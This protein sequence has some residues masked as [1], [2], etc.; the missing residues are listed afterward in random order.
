MPALPEKDQQILASH[1][2]LVHAVVQTCHNRDLMP[3]LEQLLK[4]SEENGWNQLVASI[5]RIV[6]GQRDINLLQNLD[7][8]DRVITEAILRGLQNPETL[9]DLS[10]TPDPEHAAPGLASM[11]AAARHGN[12]EALKALADMAIQMRNAGGDM[13]RLASALSQ[14]EQGE[15]DVEK[16]SREMSPA[17]LKLVETILEELKKT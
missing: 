14:M 17:G 10:A 16:L 9:P 13:A 3:Q 2:G 1:A 8:E 11:V 15:D 4:L 12:V 6:G 5:R 7:E